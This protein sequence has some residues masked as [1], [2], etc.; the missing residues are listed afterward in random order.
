MDKKRSNRSIPEAIR[1]TLDRWLD[2]EKKTFLGIIGIQGDGKSTWM[3]RIGKQYS[4]IFSKGQLLDL[5]T[6]FEATEGD[7]RTKRT[8]CVQAIRDCAQRGSFVVELL[9]MHDMRSYI[10][11]LRQKG[12][13]NLGILYPMAGRREENIRRVLKREGVELFSESEWSK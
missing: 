9:P 12:F 8:A 7:D 13:Q 1:N 6:I 5:D 3:K 4:H 2:P 10:S 11:F